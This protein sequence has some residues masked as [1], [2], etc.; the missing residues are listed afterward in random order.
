MLKQHLLKI[1]VFSSKS[2]T[3]CL[4]SYDDYGNIYEIEED[5]LD[6]EDWWYDYADDA[7]NKFGNNWTKII[8]T[9]EDESQGRFIDRNYYPDGVINNNNFIYHDKLFLI[10]DSSSPNLN[11]CFS[12]QII[13]NYRFDEIKSAK[14]YEIEKD[15]SLISLIDG[16]TRV[17][18]GKSKV[19]DVIYNPS[20]QSIFMM[21]L[22]DHYKFMIH[23]PTKDK[24][25]DLVGLNKA[26]Q[27]SD[28]VYHKMLE[29][30]KISKSYGTSDLNFMEKLIADMEQKL[31]PQSASSFYNIFEEKFCL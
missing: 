24:V 30:K 2:L 16:F 19:V 7:E 25:N 17:I 29:A 22:S 9:S 12:G 31:H 5:L 18:H 6:G 8:I 4:D 23:I 13:F 1:R 26:L 15:E 28:Y 20:P 14:Y 21:K 10:G 11:A 27:F 3:D